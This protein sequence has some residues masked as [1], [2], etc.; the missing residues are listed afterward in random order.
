M[1]SLPDSST[2]LGGNIITTDS[3]VK[4]G[5]HHTIGSSKEEEEGKRLTRK[6]F[7]IQQQKKR[8][9]MSSIKLMMLTSFNLPYGAI[10][11]SMGNE[12]IIIII[13]MFTV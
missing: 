2:P 6:Q 3:C 10:C 5:V 12:G 8:E 7:F 9:H 4:Y 13:I 1:V 11:G